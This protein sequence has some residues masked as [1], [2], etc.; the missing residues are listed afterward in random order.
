MASLTH[1]DF[2]LH[3]EQIQPEQ[4]HPEQDIPELSIPEL[5]VPELSVLEQVII[6]QSPAILEPEIATNNQPSSSNLAL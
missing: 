6:D 2:V 5:F 4:T 1:T 3:S